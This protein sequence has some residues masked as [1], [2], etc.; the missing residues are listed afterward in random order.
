MDPIGYIVGV[1]L[2]RDHARSAMPDAP[3]IPDRPRRSSRPPRTAG[4]R[5]STATALRAVAGWVEP[6]PEPQ[7]RPAH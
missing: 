5:Q 2:T 3:V 1:R 7:C 6:K 4:L